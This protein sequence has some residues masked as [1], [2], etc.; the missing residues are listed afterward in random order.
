MSVDVCVCVANAVICINGVEVYSRRCPE[1]TF[2]QNREEKPCRIPCML[3][4]NTP[5]NVWKCKLTPTVKIFV[6]VPPILLQCVS[7]FVLLSLI[8]RSVS[9]FLVASLFILE[10][11]TTQQQHNKRLQLCLLLLCSSV[12]YCVLLWFLI[13]D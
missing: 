13:L 1:W 6:K 3:F 11:T 5:L 8:F 7:Y 2:S 10:A 9:S 12:F 4:C